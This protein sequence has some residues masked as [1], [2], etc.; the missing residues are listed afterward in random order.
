MSAD[1]D[2]QSDVPFKWVALGMAATEIAIPGSAL[3]LGLILGAVLSKDSDGYPGG[4]Q[5][6][7]GALVLTFG[8]WAMSWGMDATGVTQGLRSLFSPAFG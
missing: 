3:F 4:L 7:A 2:F 1:F 6:L 8:G 5:S